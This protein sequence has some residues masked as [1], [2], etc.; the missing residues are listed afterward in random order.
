MPLHISEIGVKL[1]VGGAGPARE[2]TLPG[3]APPG[4]DQGMT[5]AEQQEIVD[6][7]TKQVLASLKQERER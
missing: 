5:E 1:A 4:G 3:E 2:P 7:C 6:N